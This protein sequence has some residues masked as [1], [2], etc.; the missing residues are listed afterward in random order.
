MET[1]VLI[2]FGD[3]LLS[4]LRS[5]RN[6]SWLAAR[7][8][9]AGWKVN[10]IEIVEDSEEA[11]M[12]VFQRWVG[13][14]DLIITSGGLGPT[15]DDRT[16]HA[17]ASYLKCELK[18]EDLAYGKIVDRYHGEMRSVIEGSRIPQ[19]LVPE[20]SEPVHNPVGS[21]LGLKFKRAGTSVYSFPGIP[22]EYKAMAEQELGKSLV[23]KDCWTSIYVVGWAES[24]LK[25]RLSGIILQPGLHISILPSPNI[26][27][28]VIRGSSEHIRQVDR[29]IRSL[30]P[31]D[32]LPPGISTL[33]EAIMEAAISRQ[34]VFSLAESCTGGLTGAHLTEIPGMSKVFCGSAVCYSNFSKNSILGVSQDILSRY[35]AVSSECAASMAAGSRQVYHS[36]FAVSITGVAGPDG[37]TPEKPVGT[38]W[39]GV[40]SI[41]GEKTFHRLL[42]GNRDMIRRR[43]KAVAL[44][45]LWKEIKN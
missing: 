42:T 29:T 24:V 11:I 31:R 8:H 5:D 12:N 1:V 40:S 18:P 22:A 21:A 16:R 19:A 43:A 33:E 13:S 39:F 41:N 6:C 35:G 45:L 44:E 10:A 27:E 34:C 15:H 17:I 20:L 28:I 3:E 7:F 38:I 30:F 2:A 4:G 25:E 9:D 26:I 36:D 32:C 23:P 37:G 14:V